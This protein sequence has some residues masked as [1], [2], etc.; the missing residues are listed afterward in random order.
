VESSESGAGNC[1]ICVLTVDGTLYCSRCKETTM[2]PQN[3]LC[4]PKAAQTPSCIDDSIVDGVRNKCTDSFF[5]MNGGCYNVNQPP[6]SAMC[7]AVQDSGSTCQVSADG[8]KLDGSGSL[9]A[10]PSN[11]KIARVIACEPH[12]WLD[13]QRLAI[14]VQNALL[15]VPRVC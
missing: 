3:S 2:Y 11:C 1:E 9:V 7:S 5:L 8:Y 10:C 4:A 13:M 6:G 14:R 15:A 12:A